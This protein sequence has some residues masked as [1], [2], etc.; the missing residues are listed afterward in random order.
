MAFNFKKDLFG[1]MPTWPIFMQAEQ[2][3]MR[4]PTCLFSFFLSNN[5]YF[6]KII[7]SL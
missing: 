2:I 6:F 3:T 5:Y 7:L 4:T 1:S